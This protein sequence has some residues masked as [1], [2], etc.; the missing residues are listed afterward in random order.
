MINKEDI[1]DV[2]PKK[3]LKK[4]MNDFHLN[5]N[6]GIHGIDHWTRVLIN[7]LRISEFNNANKKVLIVFAFFHDIRREHE[8][9]DPE[10]G[11]R[12]AKY[13]QSFKYKINISKSEL[14]KA[15]IAC[16]GHTHIM[17]H[18]DIDVA[19]CWDADRLDL[20]R[21]GVKPDPDRLN[22]NYSKDSS[23]ISEAMK[24]SW[25]KRE[26]WVIDLIYDLL[27]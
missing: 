17:H 2:I 9:G 14:D 25:S 3:V 21:V 26:D 23:N 10:H 15:M 27:N 16:E 20:Y 12:A 4:I 13:L 11:I 5:I 7:G 6:N 18:D 24:H 8:A 1:Y 22:S 19:S